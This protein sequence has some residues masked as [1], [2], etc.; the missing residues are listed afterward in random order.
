MTDQRAIGMTGLA[1]T[2]ALG[3]GAEPQLAA[4][5]AGVPGFGTVDRFDVSLRRVR[6]AACLAEVGS[7]ATELAAAIGQACA[8]AGLTAEQRAGTPLLLAIHGQPGAARLAAE[9][10]GAAG[11]AGPER[12]YTSACVSA[13]SAVAD[14]GA[15]IRH[16]VVDRVVVAAGY[17]VEPEQFALFDAGKALSGD[18]A[19]RPFSQHRQGL[20]L[21]DGVAAVVLEAADDRSAGLQLLGWG[22]AGDG[23]HP[24]QPAPDGRGLA[25]A[26]RAAL[27]RA[28]LAG[29]QLGY[30]NANATGTQLSDAAEAAALRLAFGELAGRLP[31]SSTKSM[32]G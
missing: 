10:A 27:R 18:G 29:G 1:V 20:L 32:H 31:I 24:C 6:S 17:L 22:R 23:Y 14:A 12:I 30:I 25:R 7:L 5:L 26:I 16:G 9:L 21:G 19:V 15:L 8:E 13:S 28:G 2:T 4:V 11:L 3:R